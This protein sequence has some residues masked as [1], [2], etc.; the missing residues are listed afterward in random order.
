MTVDG[1]A[2]PD[3]DSVLQEYARLAPLYE[4]KWSFYVQATCRETLSRM[5]ITPTDS[6]LDVGCGTGALLHHLLSNVPEADL[7][8]VDPSPEMLTMARNRLPVTI[9]LK[10]GWAEEIPYSSDTFDTVVSCNMFHYI[11]QPQDA[12]EETLRVLRPGGTLVISDWCDD[13]L[14]CRIC[15]WYLRVFNA[16]HFRTYNARECLGLLKSARA[17]NVEIDRYKITRLWGLMT[18]T[19]QKPVRNTEHALKTQFENGK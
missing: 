13:Y 17:I 2:A 11:R 16:A 8:G 19:A 4:R 15:D 18:A 1:H 14:A 12:L 5:R 7:A 9:E 10:Q 6:I 3:R